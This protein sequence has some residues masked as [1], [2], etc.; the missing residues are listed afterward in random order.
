MANSNTVYQ[1]KKAAALSNPT[2]ASVF[3]TSADA[4]K[5]AIVYLPGSSKLDGKPF[6]V[7]AVG[8]ATGGTTTNLTIVIQQGTSVTAGSNTDCFTSGAKAINS[9]N[10][11][12]IVEF[13]GSFDATSKIIQGLGTGM[14]ND[15]AVAA[16]AIT[17]QTAMDPATEGI[18]FVVSAVFSATN[19]GNTVSLTD[20]SLEQL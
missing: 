6:R 19:A 20:F 10:G 5:P 14:V 15:V 12:F 18:G 2:S 11:N 1:A 7:R 4:T 9:V 17:A 3:V 8:K 16:A 13:I